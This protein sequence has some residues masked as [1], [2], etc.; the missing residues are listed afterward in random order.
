M[1]T[2]VSEKYEQQYVMEVVNKMVEQGNE[3]AKAGQFEKALEQFTK[4]KQKVSNSALE[5]TVRHSIAVLY[6]DL[7]E[8]SRNNG[9]YP[10]ALLFS[11]NAVSEDPNLAAG[12]FSLGTERA[13]QGYLDEAALQ[14]E[15]GAELFASGS[16]ERLTPESVGSNFIRLGD[17]YLSRSLV[18]QAARMYELAAEYARGT[19]VGEIARQRF[20][21][22]R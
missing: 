17:L 6:C 19:T 8:Q 7:A 21:N 15:Q 16:Q 18:N 10:K 5:R 13:R 2:R 22:L 20:E 14:Y 4:A 11:E 3:F 1:L 9:D 12:R